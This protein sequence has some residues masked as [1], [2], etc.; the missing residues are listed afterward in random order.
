MRHCDNIFP[1]EGV[2]I[3]VNGALL[4]REEAAV[5]SVVGRHKIDL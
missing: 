5:H 4:K 1:I 2:V 3:V